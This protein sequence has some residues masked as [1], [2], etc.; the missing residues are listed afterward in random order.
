MRWKLDIADLKKGMT[1]ARNQIKL[2]NAEF[3]N[4]TAG[5]G[6]WS[7]S[8]TGVAAKSQQL[9][10]VLDGQETILKG[11]KAQYEIV[12]REM[13][14]TS[15]EA[16]R[17]RIQIENQE[18]ACKRTEAQIAEYT[19]KLDQLEEEQRQAESPLS[20][21][22]ATID[23]QESALADLKREYAGSIV[24]NNPQDA[25]RLAREIQDLSGELSENKQKMSDAERAA[26][27]LDK[28][29]DDAG[30]SASEAA[31][32]GFTVLKGALADLISSGIQEAISFVSG[33]TDEAIESADALQKFEGTMG[34]AGFDSTAIEAARDSV[35]QYAD[36]T[37][38]DLDTIANTTAQ[39]AANGVEDFTGLTQAAGNLNAVAGGNADTFNS[40][41]MVLTQTAGAGKLTTENWNQLA[42]A[43][44]GASGK[45]QEA[46]LNAGAYTGDFREA[47]ANGEITA[48]EFN[49][50]IMALGNEPVAVEAATSVTTFEGAMGNL[51]ATVVSALMEIY[52]QIGSENITGFITDIADGIQGMLPYIQDAVQFVLDNKDA[53]IAAIAGIAAGIAAATA[54]QGIMAAVTAFQTFFALVQSGQ[55]IMAALNA[56]MA[57][58]PFVLIAGAVIGLVTAMV[59]LFNTNEEFRTRVLEVWGVV[60]DFVSS[61]VT[62][63]AGFF[64]VTLPAA[65][66]F[67]LNWFAQLPTRIGAYLSSALAKARAWA[68]QVAA[69]AAAAG[70]NMLSNVISF[71]S[72]LPTKVG[73]YLTDVVNKVIAWGANLASGGLSAA[74]QLF[75]AVT[76]KVAEIPSNVAN[77]GGD[78]VRG[79]WNGING[80]LGWIKGKISG[81]VGDV[82]GFLKRLFG[83]AS[84][85]K[86]MRDEVGKYLAQGIAVG[87]GDEMPNVMRSMQRDMGGMVD[88]LRGDVGIAATGITGGGSTV[89]AGGYPTA[90]GAAVQNVYFEQT[91]NSPNAIDRLSIYRDTKSLLFTAKGGL[92][93]V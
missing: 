10:K 9:A 72:Q 57:V 86:V 37:V 32:G 79:I 12:A 58:N 89:G 47:M 62:T 90:T 27:E 38:Y 78:L 8:A 2:A 82:T 48:D 54:V 75:D 53:I 36:D 22:N 76:S 93:H 56:V 61:A 1:D 21:L 84:P 51:E 13:G 15:P 16:Q 18:A 35:K 43:I 25:E 20:K 41:A 33:L 60:R 34:F 24:G 67:M 87:F 91:I 63:I 52:E 83:I 55:G 23:E 7:D 70:R 49:A 80:N 5:M 68:T 31:S 73:G 59:V 45:L 81:W 44:P 65:I 40:V 85:S 46:L 26:D 71:V 17:L 28:S 29:I 64:T 69:T 42:N 19:G 74:Q 88:N 39:L 77:V 14:E 11:L 92:Q 66:T 6:K 30:D 50:A 3:K 4:A